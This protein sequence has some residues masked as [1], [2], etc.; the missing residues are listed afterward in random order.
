MK[1]RR[2]NILKDLHEVMSTM[3]R[4]I[5]LVKNTI[6]IGFGTMLPKV[7]GLVT[8]PII[9]GC[10]TKGEM[11]TYDIITTIISLFLPVITLQIQTAAF[12]FLLECE[13]QNERKEIISTMLIFGAGISIAAVV[14]FYFVLYRF[15]FITRLLI[16]LYFLVDILL[17]MFQQIARG[18]QQNKLYS[19]SAIIVS[20]FNMIL[21]LMTVQVIQEGLNGV[22]FSIS[23]ATIAA[24]IYVSVRLK[25]FSY[26]DYKQF[27]LIR[28]KEM[29]SY[30]WPMIPNSLSNWVMNLSDRVVITAS[31]GLEANAIYSVA[32]K[33]PNLFTSVQGTFVMAWQENAS[34]A[35]KDDDIAVYYTKMFESVFNILFGI[36]ACL[37]SFSPILFN[38]LVR[39]DYSDAYLQMPILY[40]G[41]LFSAIAS[42]IGGIYV[43]CK[44]TKSIGF[45]T[46]VAAVI[47]L[48]VSISL[49]KL[50]GIYAGS[51]STLVSFMVLAV[52]RMINIRKYVKVDYNIVRISAQI[53]IL[54]ALSILCYQQ[55]LI[56]DI[57]CIIL[58]FFSA[59]FFN[60]DVIRLFIK[61]IK[62]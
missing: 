11:G 1:S 47:N 53:F 12:R 49:V 31:L 26:F 6:I 14:T 59:V 13:T 8:L 51:V 60:L 61:K 27:S 28:L 22:F 52:F 55:K 37:I 19:A 42:F 25:L 21:V 7:A 45:T 18:L 30:S 36:M 56:F 24:A 38:I 35:S 39:G 16:C 20:F 15:Q 29:L 17:I 62:P 2:L 41:L 57:I 23:I 48:L 54:I 50:I 43:A 10:L 4:E 32:N 58:A 5:A 46:I 44:K 3:K 9:T 33:I 34:I 40:I